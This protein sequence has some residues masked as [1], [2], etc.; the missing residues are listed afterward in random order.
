MSQPWVQK[1]IAIVGIAVV[2][3]GGYG[4]V[5]SFSNQQKTEQDQKNKQESEAESAIKAV[6]TIRNQK[7]ASISGGKMILENGEKLDIVDNAKNDCRAGDIIRDYNKDT[8]N[9]SCERVSSTGGSTYHSSYYPWI[10]SHYWSGGQYTPNTT[11]QNG[12]SHLANNG[13]QYDATTKSYTGANGTKFDIG[14]AN[15][16]SPSIKKTSPSTGDTSGHGGIKSGS[17]SGSG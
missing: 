8:E 11:F 15:G 16:N 3:G 9:F 10:G 7:I 5:Q 6:E 12:V 2:A 13:Y 4:A 14:P 1:I 17:G